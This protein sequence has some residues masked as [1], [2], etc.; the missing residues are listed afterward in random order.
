MPDCS[1]LIIIVCPRTI[2]AVE[3]VLAVAIDICA[4]ADS[5]SLV[6]KFQSRQ[7]TAHAAYRA[8]HQ[9]IAATTSLREENEVA[10]VSYSEERWAGCCSFCSVSAIH[11]EDGRDC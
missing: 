6:M 9:F 10:V 3:C 1:P 4:M 5:V 7:V 2:V 8:E 11:W